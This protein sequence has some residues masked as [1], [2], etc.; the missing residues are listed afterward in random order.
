MND[1]AVQNE[2]TCK[3]EEVARRIDMVI[4]ASRWEPQAQRSLSVG[5][6]LKTR[7]PTNVL[8]SDEI[9]T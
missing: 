3:L 7:G 9:P 6:I 8:V 5:S 2:L 4:I 1:K